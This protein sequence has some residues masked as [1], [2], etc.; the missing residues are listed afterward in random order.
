MP[1]ARGDIGEQQ[2]GARQ[3]TQGAEVMLADPSREWRPTS[4]A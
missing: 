4:S 1:R 2:I 3:H